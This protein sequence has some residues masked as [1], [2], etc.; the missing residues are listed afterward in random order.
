MARV[1]VPDSVGFATKP[2]LALAMIARAIGAGVPFTW[3]AADSVY[4][5]GDIE[6][7]LRRAGKGYVLGVNAN[8]PFRSWAKP[9]AIAG[10]VKNIAESLPETAWRRRGA[11]PRSCRPAQRLERETNLDR[12]LT[13]VLPSQRRACRRCAHGRL[14]LDPVHHEKAPTSP[15]RNQSTTKSTFLYLVLQFSGDL[16]NFAPLGWG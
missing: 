6:T 13:P 15:C 14:R 16:S 7:A 12:N 2:A 5:V 8:H 4:G 10:T 3:V 11:T 1:H 9:Q